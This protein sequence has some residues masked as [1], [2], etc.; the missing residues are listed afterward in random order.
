MK[1]AIDQH[2]PT[3]PARLRNMARYLLTIQLE[4]SSKAIDSK[5]NMRSYFF[6]E[7]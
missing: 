6:M 5:E 2:H 1:V 7:N 3:H 4:K